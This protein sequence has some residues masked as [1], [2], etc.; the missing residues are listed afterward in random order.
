[1]RYKNFI[2]IKISQLNLV[3]NP[4]YLYYYNKIINIGGFDSSIVDHFPF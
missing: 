4:L 2:I 1:M 3:T